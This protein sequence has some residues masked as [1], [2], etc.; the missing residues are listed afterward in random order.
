MTKKIMLKMLEK[1]K[2]ASYKSM[3][4]WKCRGLVYT[5]RKIIFYL[6]MGEI[7]VFSSADDILC[8]F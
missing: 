6:E 2:P 1:S 8:D 3:Y 4:K 5:A 7:S